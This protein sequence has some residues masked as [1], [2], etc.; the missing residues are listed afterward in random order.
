V[1]RSSNG[2]W[3]SQKKYTNDLLQRA[4]MLSCKPVSTPLATGTKILVHEGDLLSS[5]DKTKY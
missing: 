1:Q 5:E 2:L 3:L 4:G